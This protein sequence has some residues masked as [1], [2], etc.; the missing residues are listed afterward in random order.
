MK[1]THR[2]ATV[3]SSMHDCTLAAAMKAFHFVSLISILTIACQASAQPAPIPDVPAT[4]RRAPEHPAPT[5]SDWPE[6]P[7]ILWLVIEDCSPLTGAYGNPLANT[8]T[9]D[10]LAEDGLLFEAAFSPSGVCSPSRNAIFTGCWP[11][12]IGGMHHSVNAGKANSKDPEFDHVP[13]PY[14]AI[15]PADVHLLPEYLRAAGYYCVNHGKHG[16]QIN[17]PETAWDPK[18]KDR[19]P[20]RGRPGHGT[21]DAPP[22]FVVFNDLQTHESRLPGKRAQPKQVDRSAIDVPPYLPDTPVQR[23]CL[24]QQMDNLAVSDI[25][26]AEILA[27]LEEDG[28]SENTIVFFFGDHGSATPRGKRWL[29]DTGTRVPL[30]IRFPDGWMAGKRTDQLVSFVDFAPTLLSLVGIDVPESMQG[31]PFLGSQQAEPKT[32]LFHA[33]DRTDRLPERIRSI[34][35]ADFRYVKHYM[36]D[37]PRCPPNPYGLGVKANAEIKELAEAG[38]LTAPEQW[39]MRSMTKPNEEE[40]YDLR[41]DPHEVVNLVDDPAYANVLV[42][43]RGLLE[44]HQKTH[45]DLGLMEEWE[46]FRQI[47]PEGQK[48]VTAAPE[49]ARAGDSALTII[50][51]TEGASLGWQYAGEKTWRVYTGPFKPDTD[52]RINLYAHSLGYRPSHGYLEP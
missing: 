17:P 6:R 5:C 29:L 22:F 27:D 4:A 47:W 21:P 43:M 24:A 2:Q 28:L 38:K 33:R 14:E 48:P 49:A 7:N 51:P 13:P 3:P 1:L 44:N 39:Q 11:T 41:N 30:I 19:A 18:P 32:H 35:T 34:R 40:L 9:Y 50:C 25:R 12:S 31:K 37:L 45:G 23:D 15:P 36:L 20:W 10:K 42:E 26:A 52:K 8:P 16:Y 46:Y